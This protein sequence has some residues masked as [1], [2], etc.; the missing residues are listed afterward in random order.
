MLCEGNVSV[1]FFFL[2]MS[3][4]FVFIKQKGNRSFISLIYFL[5]CSQTHGHSSQKPELCF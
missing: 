4:I 3:F 1:L 2:V 5:S